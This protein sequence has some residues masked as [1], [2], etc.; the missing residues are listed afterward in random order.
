MAT[1]KEQDGWYYLETEGQEILL[2]EDNFIVHLHRDME[3]LDKASVQDPEDE[4]WW[5]WYRYD[6]DEDVFNS[7][8]NIAQ[9]VGTV[10][11]RGK[12]FEH[13]REEFFDQHNFDGEVD[14]VGDDE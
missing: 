5:S 6:H 4:M 1:F 9:L 12:P 13:V 10:V 2:G 7:I 8:A 3:L 14:T 11:L